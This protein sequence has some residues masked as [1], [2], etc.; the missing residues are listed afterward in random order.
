MSCIAGSKLSE[1]HKRNIGLANKGNKRPDLSEFNRERALTGEHKGLTNPNYRHGNLVKAT[2][3]CEYCGGEYIGIIASK[4]CSKECQGLAKKRNHS[5][6]LTCII[7]GT[8]FRVIKYYSSRKYCSLKCA[9][10]NR[11]GS[12]GSN[13][14]G[15]YQELIK[16]DQ[17]DKE[18]LIR[19][20]SKS[21]HHFCSKDC[22]SQYFFTG[23]RNDY[24]RE[25]RMIRVRIRK[26]DNYCCR[27][28]E[29]SEKENRQQLSVHHI[30]QNKR[31][32]KFMN[33][34]S[35]CRV[36]H[37]KIPHNSHNKRLKEQWRTKLTS[38]LTVPCV[39]QN[40]KQNGSTATIFA[41]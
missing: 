26:R 16:C 1:R 33:L 29:K 20:D 35:L 23:L 21:N 37:W 3:I 40:V 30:D 36:C 10:S 12:D 13:W 6:E 28:C 34:I 2:A 31:N 27:I 5:T 17:C 39:E 4:Y 38:I 41:G 25:F 15:G 32:S 11:G 19:K 22:V 24:P 9:F 8:K 14:K 18:I 7:C